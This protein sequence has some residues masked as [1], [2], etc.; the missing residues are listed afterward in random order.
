MLFSFNLSPLYYLHI[1]LIKLLALNFADLF[2][3]PSSPS[4]VDIHIILYS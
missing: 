1:R 3:L 2:Y 4:V